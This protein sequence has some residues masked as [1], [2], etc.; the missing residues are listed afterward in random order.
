MPIAFDYKENYN[1]LFTFTGLEYWDFIV[2]A[3]IEVHLLSN[4]QEEAHPKSP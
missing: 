1:A 4:T 2:P 3:V